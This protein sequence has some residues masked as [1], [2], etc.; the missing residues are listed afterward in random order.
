M[1]CPPMRFGS[2]REI[3]SNSK[4]VLDVYERHSQYILKG[5]LGL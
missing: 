3:G 2:T 5:V 1:L 4:M